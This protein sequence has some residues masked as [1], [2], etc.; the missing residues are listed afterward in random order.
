MFDSRYA[1]VL[2]ALGISLTITSG[3]R[4]QEQQGWHELEGHARAAFDFWQNFLNLRRGPHSD[5][6]LTREDADRWLHTIR[7][8]SWVESRHGTGAGNQPAR[9]PMQAGNPA[10]AWWRSLTRQLGH[11]DRIIG[12]PNRGQW[13]CDEIVAVAEADPAFPAAAKI[14]RLQDRA[15]GHDDPNFTAQMSV[16]WGV[17]YLIHRA[18]THDG[19]GTGRRTYKCGDGSRARLVDG[20]VRYNGGGDPRYRRKIEAALGMFD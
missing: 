18:N 17:L 15:H 10:D 19:L 1:S 12:G 16:Y 3:V 6:R 4:E 2:T 11:G 20:A 8:V 9:D 5:Q 13:W 7:A 14:S